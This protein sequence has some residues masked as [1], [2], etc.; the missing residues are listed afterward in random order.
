MGKNL[1]RPSWGSSCKSCGGGGDRQPLAMVLLTIAVLF[2]GA[3]V[4]GMSNWI[5]GRG[6]KIVQ[7]DC[8]WDGASNSYVARIL[9]ANPSDAYKQFELRVQARLRPPE[10]KRWPSQNM[11]YRYEATSQSTQFV[12]RPDD[13]QSA[14]ISFNIPEVEGFLCSANAMVGQQER[15]ESVPQGATSKDL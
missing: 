6:I 8:E 14:S 10:G 12:L 3:V 15:L 2:L 9:L 11:R 7:S 4:V 5:A 13:Q 1:Y